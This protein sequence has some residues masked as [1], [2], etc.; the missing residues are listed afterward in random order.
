MIQLNRIRMKFFRIL[1]YLTKFLE[2]PKKQLLHKFES[3]NEKNLV[4]SKLCLLTISREILWTGNFPTFIICIYQI[5]LH[6]D[7]ARIE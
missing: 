1:F 7:I 2:N 3:I 4:R 6:R 5:K